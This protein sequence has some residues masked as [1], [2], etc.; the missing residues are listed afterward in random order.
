MKKTTLVS[1]M[2]SCYTQTQH[3]TMGLMTGPTVLVAE[4]QI[5]TQNIL[6]G[7]QDFK[8]LE[9]PITITDTEIEEKATPWTPKAKAKKLPA[10]TTNAPGKETSP[11]KQR[12][13]K[14]EIHPMIKA[15]ITDLLPEK[16]NM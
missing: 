16:L 14:V 2:W 7:A 10:N 5:M 4:W 13:I 8:C 1:I 6:S 15:K 12:K 11:P 9:V 3:Y